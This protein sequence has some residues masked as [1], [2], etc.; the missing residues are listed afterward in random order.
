MDEEINLSLDEIIRKR[1]LV[2][3]Q[4]RSSDGPVQRGTNVNAARGFRGENGANR[5]TPK[6]FVDARMKII[7]NKRAKMR[8][9]RDQLMELNRTRDARFRLHNRTRQADSSQRVLSA[10]STNGRHGGD[11]E[12]LKL[13]LSNRRYSKS[14]YV[15]QMSSGQAALPIP[16]YR[17]TPAISFRNDPNEKNPFERM[18]LQRLTVSQPLGTLANA[19]RT[20]HNDAFTLPST[21][22]PLPHFRT[23]RATNAVMNLN[24][25]SPLM[26]YTASSI[27]TNSD[28]FDQYEVNRRPNMNVPPPPLPPTRP[29]RS[30]L[31]TRP[32]TP[33]P[34][35]I[36]NA[37]GVPLNLSP[38]M[39]ARLERAPNP[40]KSMGIFAHGEPAVNNYRSRS[41][42]PPR[43]SIVGYRIVV[44]NLHPSVTQIDI[45]ELFEDI[46]DLLE[47]RL[48]RPGVAEV[49]YRNLKD[50]VKAVDAYHN[51][52]LDGQPMNCLLVNPRASY[53]LT[54]TNLKYGR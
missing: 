24:N 18:D 47:S 1:K 19:T 44:S 13:K 28:P 11:I 43:A 35:V 48:V 15:P 14:E 20:L 41:P 42:S 26:S 16:H 33:P 40:N 53:K 10:T 52:Q 8:D 34:P 27:G 39:R 25:S 29:L 3:R 12:H 7:K 2:S 6:P 9:A 46:G 36:S 50:A 23:V 37:P 54:S 17:P 38:S 51:R 32:T 31:R 4:E 21:M 45:K 30:I 22:P 5:R 49:I